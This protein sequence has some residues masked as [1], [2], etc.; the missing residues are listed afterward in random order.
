MPTALI[1]GDIIVYQFGFGAQKV[2][3]KKGLFLTGSKRRADYFIKDKSY[4]KI[5]TAL[6]RSVIVNNI[7]VFIDNILTLSHTDD[8]EIFLT[9]RG[10][11]SNFRNKIK[12]NIDYKGNRKDA[13]KPKDYAFIRRTLIEKFGAEVVKGH[14]ADDELG[15]KQTENTVICT[16]DK[17]LDMIPGWH[18]NFNKYEKYFINELEGLKNFYKQL[19]TGD[20]ADNIPGVPSIGP[21]KSGKILSKCKDELDMFEAVWD[22]YYWHFKTKKKAD[23]MMLETG[24]LLWILREEGKIWQFPEPRS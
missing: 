6:P 18:Y 11:G 1:D 20:R 13:A 22:K 14:E 3:Y 21:I 15:I 8:Y 12:K 16:I 5:K 2:L 7:K 17:D 4:K 24:Q 19:L 10:E 23:E 9:E